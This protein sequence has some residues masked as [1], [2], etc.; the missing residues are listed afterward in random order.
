MYQE[1]HI[2]ANGS[3][4]TI[5]DGKD[6]KPVDLYY[7]LH[8]CLKKAM[9]DEKLS[10]HINSIVVYL[11]KSIESQETWFDAS[12]DAWCNYFLQHK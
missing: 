7:K 12:C 10:C 1:I 8:E 2:G 3:V 9:A 6:R 4:E 5:L 11:A